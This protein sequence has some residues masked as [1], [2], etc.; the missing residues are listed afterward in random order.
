[1]TSDSTT[2]VPAVTAALEQRIADLEQ[3]TKFD[4]TQS[5]VQKVQWECLQQLRDIRAALAS[6]SSTTEGNGSVDNT[7]LKTMQEENQ[8]LK[9]R[10]AKLE[11]RVQH[12][13]HSLE[14]L[15][16]KAYP[17]N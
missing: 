13:A 11:Y 2:S 9:T 3:G 7:A 16:A 5:A 4:A 15:Y 8:Q 14:E 17:K 10:N 1:M 6:S 12:M